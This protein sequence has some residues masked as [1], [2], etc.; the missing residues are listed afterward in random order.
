MGA[1]TVQSGGS[2]TTFTVVDPAS[3]HEFVVDGTSFTYAD[4]AVTGG[5]ITSF[6]EFATGDTLV[7]LADFPGLSVDA[8]TWMSAV[9]QAAAGDK[10]AAEALTS[11]S[12]YIF[13]GGAGND[14]FG[15]AG[16]ADTLTGT[17]Q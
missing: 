13:N 14:N 7:A 4:G 10:T 9:Q 12:S 16:H 2:S 17:G 1:G 11:N 6:H 8:P 5:I 15:S 3:H